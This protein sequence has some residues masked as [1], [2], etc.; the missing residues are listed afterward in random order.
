M[1]AYLLERPSKS[2]TLRHLGNGFAAF[3]AESDLLDGTQRE[4]FE[5]VA[6]TEYAHMEVFEAAQGAIPEPEDLQNEVIDL[7]EHVI[8]LHLAVPADL[9]WTW[10][11]FASAASSTRE[12]IDLAVWRDPSGRIRHERL[13]PA[14]IP[15]LARPR[16]GTRLADLF[17]DLPPPS[18]SEEQVGAWFA[19]WHGHRWLGVRGREGKQE[20]DTSAGWDGMDRMSSQ[21]VRME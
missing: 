9:C 16:Q 21:A 14:E 12:E 11:D 8:L 7:Q 3:V 2:F 15:L 13:D 4:W 20:L 5:A 17:E 1:E 10:P 6:R 19:K 18:P